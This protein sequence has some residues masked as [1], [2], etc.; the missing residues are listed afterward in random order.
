MGYMR[1]PPGVVAE[2]GNGRDG[3]DGRGVAGRAGWEARKAAEKEYLFTTIKWQAMAY[4]ASEQGVLVERG[5]RNPEEVV[6]GQILKSINYGMKY[7]L[8][9]TLT[10]Y[11]VAPSMTT[12][13]PVGAIIEMFSGKRSL[14]FYAIRYGAWNAGLSKMSSNRTARA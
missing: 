4:L 13:G 1:I 9:A 11:E 6:P 3:R 7:G 2:R 10:E 8:E 12:P 14:G 5:W